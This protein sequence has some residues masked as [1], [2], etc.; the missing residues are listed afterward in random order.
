MNLIYRI[1]KLQKDKSDEQQDIVVP[2]YFDN[3]V[4]QRKGPLIRAI[5][6]IGEFHP[7]HILEQGIED[8]DD[9]SL[10]EM[11]EN[12]KL[13]K[14]DRIKAITFGK[15]L[16]S[17]LDTFDMQSSVYVEGDIHG[18]VLD[19]K[20]SDGK[21]AKI[22]PLF[23]VGINVNIG[24]TKDVYYFRRMYKNPSDLNFHSQT[25]YRF[26]QGD[27]CLV[28]LSH[29]TR[30]E[31]EFLSTGDAC[32]QQTDFVQ[33][34]YEDGLPVTICDFQSKVSNDD[35][36]LSIVAEKVREE[37]LDTL[38]ENSKVRIPIGTLELLNTLGEN[39]V[40]NKISGNFRIIQ[41]RG[42]IV[43]DDFKM[44]GG[45]FKSFMTRS[46]LD[47]ASVT[48]INPGDWSYEQHLQDKKREQTFSLHVNETNG[49][50][51]SIEMN[52]SSG[53]GFEKFPS[54]EDAYKKASE[55]YQKTIGAMP[56]WLKRK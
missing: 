56:N 25:F 41:K 22:T 49:K 39:L 4:F 34:D 48:T 5:A 13:S 7:D 43:Y 8:Y 2:D 52:A 18:F 15:V 40:L 53:V 28:A 51:P 45:K 36:S 10:K 27:I 14:T 38:I 6:F 42:D 30:L 44:Y 50:N 3:I 54:L 20:T 29:Q 33:T 32:F 37:N 47:D 35:Y 26:E 12:K 16:K 17:I 21:E 46:R 19:C 1:K 31:D 11:V 24:N 23:D 9:I 55:A